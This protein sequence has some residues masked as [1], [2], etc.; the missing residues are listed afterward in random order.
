AAPAAPSGSS[1]AASASRRR[2]RII[3]SFGSAI[4]VGWAFRS[5]YQGTMLPN[6]VFALGSPIWLVAS[7]IAGLTRGR[8]FGK[9]AATTE[10][11][12]PALWQV[13]GWIGVMWGALALF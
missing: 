13:L 10:R 2:A 9:A 8:S 6:Q 5:L 12:G 4:A 3:I 11:R 7:A 1:D